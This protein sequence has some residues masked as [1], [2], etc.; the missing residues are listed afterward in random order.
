MHVS[1]REGSYGIAAGNLAA[2]PETEAPTQSEAPADKAASPDKPKPP[3]RLVLVR[4]AVTAHTGPLLSGRMPG[5]DLSEKGVGQAEATAQRLAKLPIAAVYASPI[6]RTTQTAQ[7]I[8]AHHALEVRALPGV[9]EADYGDWTGGKIADLAKSDEWK[10]VQ[11]APSRA[12]FPNGESITEMQSRTVAALDD[13]VAR[14]PNETI[15]VV[16]H[17]DPIKSAIAHYS[18]MHLDLFQRVHVSPASVTVFD[19]HSYGV[20]MVKC[21]DTGGLDDLLPEPD[22]SDSQPP[23]SEPHVS[24]EVSS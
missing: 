15:V 16:S 18:G 21:N 7:Q 22:P 23:A 5:I 24:E 2:M 6:E 3:T 1:H 17:A 4:H 10:V 12:R 20:T 14:H 8:A 13:V 19:F 9:V 11:V